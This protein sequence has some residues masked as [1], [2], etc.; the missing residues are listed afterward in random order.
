MIC[1]VTF[2]MMD[3]RRDKENRQT[4]KAVFVAAFLLGSAVLYLLAGIFLGFYIPC[5]FRAFTGLKCPGCGLSHA[6]TDLALSIAALFRGDSLS[7]QQSLENAFKDNL[8]FPLFY[9]Y[10]IIASYF[11]IRREV[12]H[13][14]NPLGMSGKMIDAANGIVLIIVLF[15]WVFRNVAGY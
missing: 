12:L 4:Q 9:A 14:Q 13:D 6:A 5:P 1:S 7:A 10:I 8:L 15:W 11:F 2:Q 3:I